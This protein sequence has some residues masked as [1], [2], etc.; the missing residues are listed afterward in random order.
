MRGGVGYGGKDEALAGN[1]ERQLR[2]RVVRDGEKKD[3]A[4]VRARAQGR[5]RTGVRARAQACAPRRCR[6]LVH[7]HAA[8]RARG[9]V[10]SPSTYSVGPLAT[11]TIARRV[12][13]ELSRALGSHT[14]L[15]WE[16][17][18]KRVAV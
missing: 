8:P 4:R 1:L 13:R 11:N 12:L 5:M 16:L 18:I 15:S 10:I 14:Q 6:A 7:V 3:G 2:W 17:C 9:E